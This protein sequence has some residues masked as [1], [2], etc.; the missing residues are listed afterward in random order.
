MPARDHAIATAARPGRW[1]KQVRASPRA[2][3]A[4]PIASIWRATL[5]HVR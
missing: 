3:A 2:A 4:T 1:S 5:C